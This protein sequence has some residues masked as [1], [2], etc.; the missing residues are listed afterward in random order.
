MLVKVGE[1]VSVEDV[2]AATGG[3][4]QVNT[5]TLTCVLTCMDISYITL[6]TV[7]ALHYRHGVYSSY[8]AIYYVC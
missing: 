3:S 8:I 4:F 1:G 7:F 2:R 5:H 6:M